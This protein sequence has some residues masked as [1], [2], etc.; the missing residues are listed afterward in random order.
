MAEGCS[1]LETGYRETAWP[2][3]FHYAFH[4]KE[5]LAEYL[6][7]SKLAHEVAEPY[8]DESLTVS[9]HLFCRMWED[10]TG[11]DILARRQRT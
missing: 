9:W 4:S 3:K 10:Q 7:L 11:Y 5:D 8:E 2:D 6:R 1:V